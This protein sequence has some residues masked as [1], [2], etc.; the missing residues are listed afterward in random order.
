MGRH[1]AI[2]IATLYGLEASGDRGG[3]FSALVRTGPGPHLAPCTMDTGSFSGVKRP[4]RSVD[5][6]PSSS[7]EVE[8]RVEFP[9]WAFVAC[10]RVKF[11]FTLTFDFIQAAGGIT[12]P[13]DIRSTWRKLFVR[14]K[15]HMLQYRIEHLHASVHSS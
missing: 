5:H 13:G 7:A 2:G 9:L 11:T 14:I 4:G 12:L 10:L 1:S 8:G 15:S 6:P 3:G